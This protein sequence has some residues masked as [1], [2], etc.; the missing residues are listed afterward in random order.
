MEYKNSKKRLLFYPDYEQN[1]LYCTSL[2]I[3]LDGPIW[4]LKYSFVHN[5]PFQVI[6]FNGMPVDQ[7]AFHLF[8]ELAR[9]TDT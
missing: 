3:N 7:Q 8:L 9:S 4:E 6:Y 5:S 2:L 1:T